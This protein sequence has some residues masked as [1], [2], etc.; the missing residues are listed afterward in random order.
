MYSKKTKSFWQ[1]KSY[2][3]VGKMVDKSF[4]H[5]LFGENEQ[6]ELGPVYMKVG[7]PM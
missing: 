3:S 5:L 6:C 4:M 2:E 7:D 1:I